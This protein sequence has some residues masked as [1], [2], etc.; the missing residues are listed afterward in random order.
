MDPTSFV[1]HIGGDDFIV[2]CSFEKAEAIASQITGQVDQKA[3]SFYNQ[4]DLSQG[5][6]SSVNRKGEAEKFNFLSIG[7]GIV[8]NTKKELL[9]FAMVSN[10]GSEMKCLAKKHAEDHTAELE[11]L[12][13][14][15]SDYYALDML[16]K[17][18]NTEIPY[19]LKGIATR[20]V[21]FTETVKAEDNSVKSSSGIS[22]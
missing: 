3:P 12:K 4:E 21:R 11:V 18:T 13:A 20:T 15:F 19:P 2:V 9:S 10:I 6:M 17:A 16:V 8:H 14:L 22:T 5:F 7:I 1:G